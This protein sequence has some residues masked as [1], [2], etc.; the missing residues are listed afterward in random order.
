[1]QILESNACSDCTQLGR[2]IVFKKRLLQ[3]QLWEHQ[4][5]TYLTRLD[6]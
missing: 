6:G 3:W 2:K 5:H 4:F 1:M